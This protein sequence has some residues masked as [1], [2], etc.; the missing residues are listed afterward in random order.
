MSSMKHLT[1]TFVRAMLGA[2]SHLAH[3]GWL[4][5]SKLQ[6]VW[7]FHGKSLPAVKSRSAP[8]TG[9]HSQRERKRMALARGARYVAC[10]L[11]SFHVCPMVSGSVPPGRRKR[12]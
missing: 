10:R 12:V 11:V 3:A 4:V 1:R 9:T 6:H 5:S 2:A 8:V 7:A